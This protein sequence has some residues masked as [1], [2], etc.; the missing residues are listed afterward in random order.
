MFFHISVYWINDR[1]AI[2]QGTIG[3]NETFNRATKLSHEW[4]VR[5]ARTDT[6]SDSPGR[7]KLAENTCLY[8]VKITDDTRKQYTIPQRNC[9]DL[10][11]HCSFWNRSGRECS[12]NPSFMHEHCAATCR[13]CTKESASDD[14]TQYDIPL[15]RNSEG[16]ETNCFAK[17]EL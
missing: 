5:D 17:D 13:I 2:I 3:P 12:R 16:E 15:E 14:P 1:R 10:S 6:F 7:Y 11:G 4:W 8:S 9:F